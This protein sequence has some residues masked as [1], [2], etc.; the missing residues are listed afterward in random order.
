MPRPLTHDLFRSVMEHFDAGVEEVQIVDLKDGIFYA[1]LVLAY[2][3]EQV[4]LDARPSDSIALALKFGAP[5]YMDGNIIQQVGFKARVNQHGLELE[6]LNPSV[7][8]QDEEAEEGVEG[9]EVAEV[10]EVAEVV[11]VV[12]QDALAQAVE[13]LVA[14]VQPKALPLPDDDIDP[15]ELLKVLKDQM[16]KAIHEER[17]EDAGMIRDEIVRIEATKT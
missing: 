16:V 14:H 3:G 4:R 9:V 8:R 6:P 10:A 12:D 7:S 15:R 1:E 17:Y 11:E 2:S 13:E 5:I